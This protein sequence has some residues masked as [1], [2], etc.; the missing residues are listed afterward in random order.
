MLTSVR[1]NGISK[2][3]PMIIIMENIM[4]PTRVPFVTAVLLGDMPTDHSSATKAAEIMATICKGTMM[5]T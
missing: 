3:I 2:T 1:F 5:T 4:Y